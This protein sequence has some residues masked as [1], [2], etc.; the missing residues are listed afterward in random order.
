MTEIEATEQAFA[1][2]SSAKTEC[3]RLF[4]IQADLERLFDK[5]EA[6]V[7]ATV[8]VA[9]GPPVRAASEYTQGERG[10][11]KLHRAR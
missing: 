6:Q 8:A 10:A 2:A 4:K 3:L 5:A 9:G 11:R 7:E 1:A